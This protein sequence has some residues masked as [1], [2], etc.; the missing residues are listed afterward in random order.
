MP[1]IEKKKEK[2][3]QLEEQK[4]N[5]IFKVEVV[6]KIRWYGISENKRMVYSVL[7]HTNTAHLTVWCLYRSFVHESINFFT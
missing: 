7:D 5:M 1:E 3:N 4:E 6:F 2:E